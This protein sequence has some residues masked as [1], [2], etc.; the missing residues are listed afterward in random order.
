MF[1]INN[2]IFISIFS[3]LFTLFS[4]DDLNSKLG[5]ISMI[6]LRESAHKARGPS[7][8]AENVISEKVP[9]LFNS[10]SPLELELSENQVDPAI[11]QN[12][13]TSRAL[14]CYQSLPQYILIKGILSEYSY[15][16]N[17]FYKLKC[18]HKHEYHD[19]TKCGDTLFLID[20]LENKVEILREKYLNRK[21]ECFIFESNAVSVQSR[22]FNSD[23]FI[24]RSEHTLKDFELL[25]LE[26][27]FLR[28][29]ISQFESTLT[30]KTIEYEI[31]C[32][33]NENSKNNPVDCHLLRTECWLLESELLSLSEEHFKRVSMFKRM[34]DILDN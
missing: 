15:F 19:G 22:Y 25:M 8:V 6:S 3:I 23:G 21:N 29:V 20:L 14:N 28:R 2:K 24:G 33:K 7:V 1:F 17:I 12:S 34:D 26:R 18:E 32:M 27:S 31:S 9:K 13:N 5:K 4:G 30:N 16:L 11:L 10:I